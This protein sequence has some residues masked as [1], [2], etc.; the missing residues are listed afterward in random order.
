MAGNWLKVE[1]SLP[2]KPEVIRIGRMLALSPEA[3]CGWLLRF[4]TWVDTNSVD[5]CVDGVVDSDVD[6]VVALP[7]F[8]SA[9]V[10][11]KWLEFDAK[12]KK[13][14][15]PNFDRHN[16]ESAKKRAL[17]TERQAR[18]RAH[19]VDAEPTTRIEKNTGEG[20]ASPPAPPSTGV[21]VLP[22]AKPTTTQATITTTP[23][24]S[25]FKVESL[26]L[27]DRTAWF[28]FARNERPDLDAAK[29]LESFAD[30]W[31]ARP[32]ASGV[33]LDW[34]ATWRNWVRNQKHG[35]N[36]VKGM[37]AAASEYLRR[38]GAEPEKETHGERV[39]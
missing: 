11:V 19:S 5:G 26:S 12:T 32:G 7:G 20:F 21:S 8:A 24:G 30:F 17:K 22:L 29:T 13:M 9:L 15:L 31:I 27:A 3:V 37:P 6:M 25:R 39:G 33:K 36:G 1:T 10:S 16:G 23:R 34:L 35:S 28:E 14:V 38:S 4:W 2:D 18:W